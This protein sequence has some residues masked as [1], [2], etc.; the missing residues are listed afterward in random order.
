MEM[1]LIS[2]LECNT[3]L[4]DHGSPALSMLDCDEIVKVSKLLHF[5]S[6]HFVLCCHLRALCNNNN[7]HRNRHLPGLD[8]VSCQ[9]PTKLV[10]SFELI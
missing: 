3:S 5:S 8:I 10:V 1:V 4:S 2:K 9:P 6:L 7:T